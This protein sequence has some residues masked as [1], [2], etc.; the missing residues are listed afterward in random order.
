MCPHWALT[1]EPKKSY[2]L[3][4]VLRST[5]TCEACGEKTP[6]PGKAHDIL[7]K[8]LRTVHRSVLIVDQAVGM[9]AIGLCNQ[10][11]GRVQILVVPGTQLQLRPPGQISLSSRPPSRL[12]RR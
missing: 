9:V 2:Q 3:T 5:I 7:Q 4:A 12:R 1:R 6:H 10:L 8:P 11:S